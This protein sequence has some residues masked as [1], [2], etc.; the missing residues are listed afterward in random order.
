VAADEIYRPQ[1]RS[2]MKEIVSHRSPPTVSVTT[3]AR[4]VI[5]S[6]TEKI[7]SGW[8]G[9]ERGHNAKKNCLSPYFCDRQHSV[10]RAFPV[11]TASLPSHLT[12]S[13]SLTIFRQRQGRLSLSTVG[14]KCA[15]DNNFGRNFIKSLTNFSIQ[16]SILLSNSLL[17]SEYNKID[18][19]WGFAPD[20]TEGAYSSPQTYWFQGGRFAAGGN[21]G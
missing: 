8:S 3:E 21:G 15:K 12:S 7:Y 10:R 14:D 19:G 5:K 1:G 6:L 18:V 9:P 4:F 11:F 16:K 13:P 17:I 2:S 20:P